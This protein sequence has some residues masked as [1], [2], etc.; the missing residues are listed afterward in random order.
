MKRIVAI[1]QARMGS[2]RLPGKV[3]SPICD[4]PMLW[5]IVERV[6][7]VPAL[8]DIVVATSHT[9]ADDPLREFGQRFGAQVFSGSL[10]D[11]LDRFY[12]AAQH[13]QAD[14]V[15]RVT[16]DCPLFDPELVNRMLQSF[17]NHETLD[18]IGVAAGAGVAQNTYCGRYPNG[19]D[20]E[21][22]AFGALETAWRDATHSLD[23]EHVTP[24]IWRQPE[25]FRVATYGSPVDYSH[26]RW[27]VD[28][29]EDLDVI[30][31]IY[32]ALY[33]PARHFLM[34]DVIDLL[35]AHPSISQH[36]QRFIGQ[37]A[38][39]QFWPLISTPC[40]QPPKAQHAA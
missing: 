17:L 26:L 28:N 29:Q 18:H 22:T 11:V 32:D 20:A 39:Q 38:Y 27:T 7:A 14:V 33:D 16:G 1:V 25:R 9:P 6:S 19:L 21:L 24:F 37:E 34:Q 8:A 4:R 30:R 23:R 31:A 40:T 35:A 15:L 2:S 3:L 5:H 12:R 10:D 36:N 13:Y